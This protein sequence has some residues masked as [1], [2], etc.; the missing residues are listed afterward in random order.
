MMAVGGLMGTVCDSAMR[1]DRQSAFHHSCSKSFTTFVTAGTHT[2]VCFP[3]G[4]NVFKVAVRKIQSIRGEIPVGSCTYSQK[5]C[6]VRGTCLD[7][8]S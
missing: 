5:A 3:E 6:A 2:A 4:L 1:Y 8:G 7:L